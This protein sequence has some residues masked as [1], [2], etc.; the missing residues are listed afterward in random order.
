MTTYVNPFTGQ[1]TSPTPS[2]YSYIVLAYT[3]PGF[4]QLQWPVNGTSSDGPV[5]SNIND[6][7]S[8]GTNL[9]ALPS[10][11][12]VSVGQSFVIRNVGSTDISVRTFN[13]GYILFTIAAG[14]AEYIYLTD[15]STDA[16]DWTSV[17]LGAGVSEANAGALVYPDLFGVQAL[18]T[19]LGQ[20]YPVTT[21]FSDTTL[22]YSDRARLAIWGG[23]VGTFNLRSASDSAIGYGW[24]CMIRNGGTGILTV[25]PDGTN[26]IDGEVTL[27][28][29]LGESVTIVSDG[30]NWHT[31]GIGR[32]NEF[33]YTQLS[34]SVTGG[35]LVLS[36]TQA[37]NTIQQY[38]G[39]LTSN[40]IVQVPP[41]VQLYSVT[42]STTG[43]YT[44]TVET[45][46]VG[47][48]TVEVEQ[49][50][51]LILISDG[52]NIYNAASGGASSTITTL[53]LGNGSAGTPSLRFVGG[54]TTGLFLPS[55]GTLGIT[56]LGDY[57]AFFDAFGLTVN[58]EITA[59]T[60]ISGG[61]F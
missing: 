27:Q 37:A 28:L 53:T 33:A 49:G 34:L 45:G 38:S 32:S 43:A 56:V 20:Q 29:Q 58:G 44:L 54:T 14:E 31:F 57:R 4:V 21:Y 51:S 47:G 60:G 9:V 22:S 17:T 7:A 2:S 24:F 36:S 50:V 23:G 15:N 42:N 8:G 55:S 30:S 3:V 48:A 39:T 46:A 41:T 26:T 1:T 35:T 6:M 59:L 12:Q 5:L 61:T 18:G 13:D 10:A 40:Q 11:Q 16:G 52:T 25:Q 19:Y